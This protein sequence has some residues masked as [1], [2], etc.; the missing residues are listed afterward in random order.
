[1]H[2]QYRNSCNSLDIPIAASLLA[3]ARQLCLFWCF[4]YVRVG[5]YYYFFYYFH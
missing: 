4:I 2:Q 3:L 5:P 1:M